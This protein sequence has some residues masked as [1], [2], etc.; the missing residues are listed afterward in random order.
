MSARR[1]IWLHKI[2]AGALCCFQLPLGIR[3]FITGAI[4]EQKAHRYFSAA[5]RQATPVAPSSAASSDS[6]EQF[7]DYYDNLSSMTARDAG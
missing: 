4:A 3:A 7:D 5:S 6:A 1:V 2:H